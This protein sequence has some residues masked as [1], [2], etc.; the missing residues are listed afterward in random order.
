MGSREQ[1]LVARPE[2]RDRGPAGGDGGCVRG[3]RRSR[4]PDPTR[5]SSRPGRGHRRAAR[6][7]A[8]R[9]RSVVGCRRSPRL[10]GGSSAPIRPRTNRTGAAPRSGAGGPDSSGR[11][12]SARRHRR[13]AAGPG[14]R[15]GPVA[16]TPSRSTIGWERRARSRRGAVPD[17]VAAGGRGRQLDDAERRPVLAEQQPDRA[18]T[19]AVDRGQHGPRVAFRD[20]RGSTGQPTDRTARPGPGTGRPPRGARGGPSR[21]RPGRRSSGRREGAVRRPAPTARPRTR[22]RRRAPRRPVGGGRPLAVGRRRAARSR[23]VHA[24][25]PRPGRRRSGPRRPRWPRPGPGRRAPPR[26]PAAS[27]PTGRSDRGADRIPGRRSAPGRP[28]RSGSRR[29][30][31]RRRHTDRGSSRPRAGSGRAV[32]APRRP[33]RS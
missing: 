8:G 31:P 18:W 5:W 7:S 33:A 13:R 16:A 6:R 24:P 22:S 27:P 1:P 26:R 2:H 23:A 32:S 4:R 14:S 19:E 17:Q 15:I 9:P 28:A 12:G 11:R 21:R 20:R 30:D 3:S 10:D 29:R 25:A